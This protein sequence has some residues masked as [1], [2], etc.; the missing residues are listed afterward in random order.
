[1]TTAAMPTDEIMVKILG[2]ELSEPQKKRLKSLREAYA[3]M[4]D[5]DPMLLQVSLTFANLLA[6]EVTEAEVE[7]KSEI[8]IERHRIAVAQQSEI[9]TKN[10]LARVSEKAAISGN[11]YNP[12]VGGIAFFIGGMFAVVTPIVL[13]HWL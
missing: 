6:N 2:R 10:M 13:K 4:K 11:A 8:F 12:I 3:L 1:M 9:A 7:K 5:D